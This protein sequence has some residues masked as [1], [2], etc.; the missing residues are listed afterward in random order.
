MTEEHNDANFE[1]DFEK[2]PKFDVWPVPEIRKPEVT[3]LRLLQM[4]DGLRPDM[5]NY[6]VLLSGSPEARNGP[7]TSYYSKWVVMDAIK[8]G[9]LTFEDCV[10]MV[11]EAMQ[12]QD[13]PPPLIEI[14]TWDK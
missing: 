14:V 8:K 13:E 3:K 12:W 4:M 2:T 10:T 11:R 7:Y 6:I 5:L 9:I 1:H